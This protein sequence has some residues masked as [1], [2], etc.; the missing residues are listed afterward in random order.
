MDNPI[1]AEH[2]IQAAG[3]DDQNDETSKDYK[4]FLAQEEVRKKRLQA[5]AEEE[6]VLWEEEVKR[7][8]EKRQ[9]VLRKSLVTLAAIAL[10]SLFFYSGYMGNSLTMFFATHFQEIIGGALV[11]GALGYTFLPDVLMSPSFR[12][13][14]I[15]RRVFGFG[16][17]S[18]LTPI[19]A[20]PFPSGNRPSDSDSPE[21][22]LK[23]ESKPFGVD[24]FRNYFLSIKEVLEEKASDAEEKA[25]LLLDK[26]TS[27]TIGG[28]VF[29]VIS[30]IAWQ[31]LSWLHGFK[32]EFIYGIVSC[33]AL[34]IF[35][36]FL[37]AWFLKQ[38]RHY[39]DT[40][41]Y[42]LKVKAIFDRYMLVYLASNTLSSSS[43]DDEQ[44]RVLINM[45]TKDITW[46]ESYLLKKEDLSFAN[47]VAKAL[48]SLIKEIRSK[49]ASK[50]S[51]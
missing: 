33:S 42:L 11:L 5:E 15:R 28:I 43:V 14:D 19:D 4:A 20:W 41:T 9:Q 32:T 37:S 34:F 40:S 36:E 22:N 23:D 8:Q 35:I 1:N 39:V 30:I 16:K 10:G 17:S 25:S 29:F 46:P 48:S 6:R 26:G 13:V 44:K 47:D 27:Y 31:V 50:G 51:M 3:V 18:V 24:P 12:D 49:D 7:Q 45:L 21:L 2:S 38:Y